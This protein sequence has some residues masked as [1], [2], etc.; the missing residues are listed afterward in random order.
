MPQD[1][2]NCW[3]LGRTNLVF[4]PQIKK[5]KWTLDVDKHLG[6]FQNIVVTHTQN[7]VTNLCKTQIS[8]Q[9]Y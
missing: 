6:I 8:A 7:M 2:L 1:F 5:D 3:F 4:L 9:V